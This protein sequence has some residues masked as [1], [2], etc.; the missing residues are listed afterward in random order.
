MAS[1]DSL[2]HH[3]R[4]DITQAGERLAALVDDGIDAHAM[5]LGALAQ[6][7]EQGASNDPLSRLLRVAAR[8]IDTTLCNINEVASELQRTGGK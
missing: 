1:I 2:K 8:L 3:T 4:I 6:A 5:L 7:E